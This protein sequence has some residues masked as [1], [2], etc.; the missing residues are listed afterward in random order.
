MSDKGS[1]PTEANI[2][3]KTAIIIALRNCPF[4]EKAATAVN[5]KTINAK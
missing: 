3:P 1:W 5:P 2:K 4:E